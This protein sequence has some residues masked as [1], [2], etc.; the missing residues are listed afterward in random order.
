MI[1]ML[2]HN[3]LR[4]IRAGKQ[5]LAGVAALVFVVGA[6]RMV[7]GW[8]ASSRLEKARAQVAAN[9]FELD[10][11]KLLP[12]PVPDDQ[13]GAVAMMECFG[14][15]HVDLPDPSRR[16]DGRFFG[17]GRFFGPM[18]AVRMKRQIEDNAEALAWL[19]RAGKMP[20]VEWEINA[21]G[22]PRQ[23]DEEHLYAA[24][25]DVQALLRGAAEVA[26]VERNDVAAIGC[27]ERLLVLARVVGARESLLSKQFASNM[28]SEAAL[29]LDR[30]E[31]ELQ[32]RGET[33]RA[34][35]QIVG[36]LVVSA[37]DSDEIRRAF[38]YETATYSDLVLQKCP[39]LDEWWIRPLMIDSFA[40]RLTR[41]MELL[42]IVEATSW[43]QVGLVP[44]ERK[45]DVSNLNN[46]VL[47]IS[48]PRYMAADVM[49]ARFHAMSDACGI[50]ETLAAYLYHEDKGAFPDR[51]AQL[52]PDYLRALPLDPFAADGRV[53]RY[54]RDA[55][56]PTVWSVGENGKD[57]GGLV[58]MTG[59]PMFGNSRR[60][61]QP[62]I[63]Y[64]AAWRAAATT[65]PVR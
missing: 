29:A 44:I 3:R 35:Q 36:E 27:L 58:S 6:I 17:F 43:Q 37:R 57:E 16:G 41:Q 8:E 60:Y 62:D 2:A 22:T 63:V 1:L 51:A 14:R 13:N 49:R 28:R 11:R 20:R 53:L 45:T 33:G 7:W 64:G 34:V 18:N 10:P 12:A 4:L 24:S 61:N 9:H 65:M 21:D 48:V 55:G 32:F 42:P 46:I 26:H 15:E 38:Q 31:P 19:D 30:W 47:S 40:R 54:R 50:A 39:A 59:L 56:G 5:F 25:F 23:I 52:V